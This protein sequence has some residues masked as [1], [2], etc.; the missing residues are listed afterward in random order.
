MKK[1]DDEV[2][3]EEHKAFLLAWMNDYVACTTFT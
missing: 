2:T 3:D 1:E